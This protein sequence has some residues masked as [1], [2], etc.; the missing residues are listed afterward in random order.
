MQKY[1]VKF[2][3]IL[4]WLLDLDLYLVDRDLDLDD[5]DLVDV[6]LDVVR[7][8]HSCPTRQGGSSQTHS[9]LASTKTRTI[10]VQ[11]KCNWFFN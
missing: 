4:T 1:I 3:Q 8:K 11:W 7:C 2:L 9:L 6:D 5:L 10:N